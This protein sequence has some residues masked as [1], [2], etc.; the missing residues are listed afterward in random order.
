MRLSPMQSLVLAFFLGCVTMWLVLRGGQREGFQDGDSCETG[1]SAA[2]Q[3]PTCSECGG[4]FPCPDHKN[5]APMCPPMPDMTKYVLKTSI[6]PCP[7]CPDLTN[8]MLKTECPPVPDLS[9]YVLKSSIPKEQPIIIDTSAD[10]R[11]KCGDCPPCPRPRCPEIKCPPPTV[12]P[13]CPPC[14][15][16]SCPQTQVKCRAE[17]VSGLGSSI[18]PYLAPLGVPGFG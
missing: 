8:Y 12:C 11:S 13:A 7:T 15:R 9:N 6:P 16:A 18:R 5:V 10:V 4:S 14:P 2:N 17:E 3:E 1:S